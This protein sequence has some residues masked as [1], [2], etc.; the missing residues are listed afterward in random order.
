MADMLI[1]TVSKN[2][3]DEGEAV[4]TGKGHAV[5]EEQSGEQLKLKAQEGM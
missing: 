2:L 5:S 3:A 4:I 1:W